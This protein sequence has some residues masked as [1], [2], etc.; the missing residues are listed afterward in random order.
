MVSTFD[1]QCVNF[2]SDFVTELTLEK[3]EEFIPQILSKVHIECLIHG[4]ADKQVRCNLQK[5]VGNKNWMLC[6]IM[7]FGC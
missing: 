6:C 5:N 3:V 2:V 1:I 7:I 4:N